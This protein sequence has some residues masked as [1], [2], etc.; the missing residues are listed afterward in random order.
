MEKERIPK[1]F[2]N[3]NFHKLGQWQ[4]QELDGRM[5]F[6]GM[7]YN[8]WGQEDGGEELQIEMNGGIL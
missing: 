2:I 1:K 6:R 3:E 5:C 7:H 8:C 4:D